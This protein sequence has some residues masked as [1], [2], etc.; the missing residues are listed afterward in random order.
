MLRTA[1]LPIAGV[2][3][4]LVS[5]FSQQPGGEAATPRP[6]DAEGPWLLL[7]SRHLARAKQGPIDLLFLGDSI[8]QSWND[9]DTW[10]RY[11]A[12]RNAANFG[13]GGDRTQHLLWRLDHGALEGYQPKVVVLLIGTNNIGNCTLDDIAEG[14][15]A[16]LTRLRTH[17]PST[18]ILLLG[19]LPR[20]GDRPPSPDALTAQPDPRVP[21]LNSRLKSLADGKSVS[22]LDI[23]P[24]F[25]NPDG[26]IP[27]ALMPDFLHFSELGYRTWADAM[28]PLLWELFEGAAASSP[29][30]MP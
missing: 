18:R 4:L 29:S 11:Y 21:A 2:A 17:F 22:F 23:G 12:P 15:K 14:V 8:T 13:I 30:S 19:V 27:K 10:K 5:G 20:Y 25:L 1:C 6:R 28:E 24:H 3:L 16:I 26:S 7:H 9:N